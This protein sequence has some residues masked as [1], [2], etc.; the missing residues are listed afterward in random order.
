MKKIALYILLLLL[1]KPAMA[2]M[3]LPSNVAKDYQN[4]D[5][6]ATIKIS[7][8]YPDKE[9][10]DYHLIEFE[11]L[12]QFKGKPI[13]TL[14]L[15]SLLNSSCSFYTP[16]NTYWLVFAKQ[17]EGELIFGNCSG[18]TQINP[19]LDLVASPGLDVKIRKSIN[20]K[21]AI[22]S[23]LKTINTKDFNKYDLWLTARDDMKQLL[24]GLETPNN[25]TVYEVKI[26]KDLSVGR[27][28]MRR[29]FGN[30]E[31]DKKL[32]GFLKANL[33]AVKLNKDQAPE[34]S[35]V[36]YVLNNFEEGGERIIS[37]FNF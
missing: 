18:S 25:F 30:G 22:L 19:E 9:N 1:G 27:L 28:K 15:L 3:C 26:N 35:K 17:K 13:K 8:I 24:Y 29:S 4:A 6:V 34:K 10:P 12:E 11:T 37:D 23:Y 14:K 31:V 16:E 5:F 21:L 20:S 33:L 36:I 2:C 32:K 7:S